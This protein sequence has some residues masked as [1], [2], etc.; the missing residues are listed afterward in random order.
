MQIL[1]FLLIT[2]GFMAGILAFLFSHFRKLMAGD[3]RYSTGDMVAKQKKAYFPAYFGAVFMSFTVVLSLI[4]FIFMGM[5]ILTSTPVAGG[6]LVFIM[7][8]LFSFVLLLGGI[9]AIVSVIYSVPT[10]YMKHQRR[11]SILFIVLGIVGFMT[12]GLQI[13]LLIFGVGFIFMLDIHH[14]LMNA[15]STGTFHPITLP[16][17]GILIGPLFLLLGGILSF[18]YLRNKNRD[19]A[20]GQKE[21]A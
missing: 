2:I 18:M 10:V 1:I 16:F 20:S 7:M 15:M 6:G 5:K 11:A 19:G 8:I 3:E 17:Y 21:Q 14:P 9:N 12:M 4:V 13:P